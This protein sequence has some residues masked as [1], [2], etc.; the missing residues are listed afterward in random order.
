MRA[1]RL[2]EGIRAVAAAAVLL[3]ATLPAA[4]GDAVRIVEQNE[5]GLILHF[6]LPELRETARGEETIALDAEGFSRV[7]LPGMPSVPI[8][9]FVIALPPGA[10]AVLEVTAERVERT[11]RYRIAP[12]PLLTR[13]EEPIVPDDP[14]FLRPLGASGWARLSEPTR[15]RDQRVATLSLLP[16]LHDW[17][18]GETAILREGTIRVRF[19]GGERSGSPRVSGREDRFEPVY[20]GVLLNYESS[21]EWR[22]APEAPA[23][24][25]LEE[26]DS[27]SSAAEWIRIE[28]DSLGLYR[29]TYEDLVAAGLT[30]PRGSIGNARKIRMYTGTGL[31]LPEMETLPRPAWMEQAAI[32]VVGEEDGS[33]D[34]GD[35]IEFYGVPLSAWLGELVPDTT[36]FWEH[37]EHPWA[38][39][40][41]Y[42]LAWGEGFSEPVKARISE[43]AAGSGVAGAATALPKSTFMD[44]IHLEE[45][46]VQDLTRYGDDGWF[47]EEYTPTQSSRFHDPYLTD[48]DITREANLRIQFYHR[49]LETQQQYCGNEVA[50]IKLNADPDSARFPWDSCRKQVDT[51]VVFHGGVGEPDTIV[52]SHIMP[53]RFDSTGYTIRNG[54]NRVVI[55]ARGRQ[56]F[57]L[58][59]IEVGYE[60]FLRARNEK[61]HFRFEDEGMLRVPIQGMNAADARVFDVSDPGNIVEMTGFASS[62]DSIVLWLSPNGGASYHAA[63]DAAWRTPPL[64]ERIVPAGLRNTSSGAEYLVICYDDFL[65]PIRDL[66][67][68]RSAEYSTRLVK[69][70]D[71]YNE[72][73]WGVPDPAAVRDFVSFAYH[74]WPEGERPLFLLLV[75]DATSEFKDYTL[76]TF[77]TLLPTR[78]RIDPAGS[79]VMT[80]AAD[81]YFTYVDPIEG[82]RDWAPDL[83]IGRFP[84]NSAGEAEILVQKVIEYETDP[85]LGSWKNRFLFL[86]DDEIKAGT[87]SG[88]D[89]GFLLTHTEDCDAAAKAI[90][91]SYDRDK[92]YMVEYPLSSAGLKPLAKEDYI[93][94]I[95]DGFLLSNYLGH[96]G[97]DKMADEDL[98]STPDVA[99]EILINGGRL[100]IFCAYSC[101]IGSFDLLDKNS[102]AEILLKMRGAGA[103]GSFSSNAPA[104]GNA[105]NQLN[106]RFIRSLLPEQN[107]TVPIGFAAQTAKALSGD[108]FY[109]QKQNDEKYTLLADPALRIAVPRYDVRLQ[110]GG[111]IEFQKG[112]VDTLFGEV[113]D[114]LGARIAGFNGLAD[115]EI[116]G[117]ADTSG[118]SF[119]DMWCT[120]TSSNPRE[121]SV[122]YSL[123]GPTF[124]RGTVEVAGGVFAAPYFVPLDTRT[125]DLGRARAYVYDASGGRD[126][127]GGTDSVSIIPEPPGAVFEDQEGPSVEITVDGA[128]FRDGISFTRNALF[129]LRLE[130]QSGINLQEIDNYFTVHMVIDRGQ[131]VVLSSYFAYDTGSYRK[132][133]L[134]VRFS[135]IAGTFLSEGVH[136]LSIRAADNLNNRTELDYQIFLVGEDEQLAFRSPVLNYPNPFDPER[137]G[138]TD[139]VVDLSR[140]AGVTVQVLTTTGKR[141]KELRGNTASGGLRLQI[142]WDGT[143]QDGDRVANGVYLVRVVAVTDD[144]SQ[145]AEEIGKAVVLRGAR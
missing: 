50:W 71:V 93:G 32:R 21:R 140:S 18:S 127:A 59:W 78:F 65:A 126:G 60:R 125:G 51:T 144:G 76:S 132:G 14:D 26:T 5:S 47:F 74:N 36:L 13:D 38:N 85:D 1:E 94:W 80:Y 89:C 53:A 28:V 20:R 123:Y 90:P 113:V 43:A 9:D 91:S 30:D 135:E 58:S 55:T 79:S 131:P 25:R 116:K 136:E 56:Q 73:S 69:L 145:K 11:D 72:F 109:A 35:R 8:R 12:V 33:F 97:T 139:I 105:S 24:K 19:R 22:S 75:G 10:S 42:W 106:V 4:A 141:I 57:Y 95:R 49:S 99:P 117:M 129:R 138:K 87:T 45:N 100:H 34:P 112:T 81:D 114:S 133:D 64:V 143:D 23:G 142:G 82:G 27:F 130:D 88:Y 68:H 108:F 120:G 104:F 61:L 83:A 17:E 122:D 128:P 86:A 92:L 111:G 107:R 41:V 124:F 115:I 52:T 101:S 102:I 121:L 134:S 31:P 77:E 137:H 6:V 84:V 37:V 98:F 2:R 7:A 48:A 40:N 39:R 29:V 63:N 67:N 103:I 3:G 46:K 66:I 70:S 118:Y 110:G 62:G 54:Y 96:G 119:L 15:L 16:V 44:R